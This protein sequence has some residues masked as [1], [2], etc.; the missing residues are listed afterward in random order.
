MYNSLN[1]FQFPPTLSLIYKYYISLNLL[2]E[3]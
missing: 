2:I 3:S 1:V